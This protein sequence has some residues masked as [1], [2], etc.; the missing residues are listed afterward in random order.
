MWICF[1]ESVL[2]RPPVYIGDKL[3]ERVD[4]FK[5][6]AMRL[7]NNLKW[8]N[9]VETVIQKTNRHVYI[10]RQCRKANLPVEVGITLCKSNIRS[11]P[12]YAS[13]VW[14]GLPTYL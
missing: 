7:Q 1:T 11:I 14:G 10:L 9:H 3:V 2:K 4:K 6:L 8:N 13:P 5:L 12:E